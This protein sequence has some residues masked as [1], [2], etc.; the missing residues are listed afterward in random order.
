MGPSRVTGADPN[1]NGKM[2]KK[3]AIGIW[4]TNTELEVGYKG[5]L[6][7]NKTDK[8]P[9]IKGSSDLHMRRSMRKDV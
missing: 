3:G 7:Y 2:I 4:K 1:E 6:I 5:R 9:L 8:Q